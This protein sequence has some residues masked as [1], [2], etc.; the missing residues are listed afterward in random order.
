MGN[1]KNCLRTH[2][3]NTKENNP[4]CGEQGQVKQTKNSRTPTNFSHAN[5][6]NYPEENRPPPAK[7]ANTKKSPVHHMWDS[8]RDPWSSQNIERPT[9]LTTSAKSSFVIH[10]D[11]INQDNNGYLRSKEFTS[12][13][14]AQFPTNIPSTLSSV[15][16]QVPTSH[17]T[18]TIG[19]VKNSTELHNFAK[20]GS[21]NSLDIDHIL[22]RTSAAEF[23]NSCNDTIRSTSSPS[24]DIC[25]RDN[26]V[27]SLLQ[28]PNDTLE[29]EALMEDDTTIQGEEAIEDE[30]IAGT[31]EEDESVDVTESSPEPVPESVLTAEEYSDDILA[32]VKR[33]EVSLR[34]SFTVK[35]WNILNLHPCLEYP[36]AF[37]LSIIFCYVLA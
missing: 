15:I 7:I 4:F 27:F 20:D 5:L 3:Q 30:I 25:E 6:Q 19:N 37:L 9:S 35:V 17:V 29:N 18:S 22:S 33:T 10:E 21:S 23:R 1:K 36:V 2:N 8:N 32:H 26:D 28:R 24:T 13:Q 16:A 34:I 14:N 11:N 12:T 31:S